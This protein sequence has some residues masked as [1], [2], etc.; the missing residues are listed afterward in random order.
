MSSYDGWLESPYTDPEKDCSESYCSLCWRNCKECDA[1]G[2]LDGVTCLA[3]EGEGQY[4]YEQASE[5][6]HRQ[7]YLDNMPERDEDY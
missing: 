1:Q 7:D 3:C 4:Y 5:G 2:E 6:E